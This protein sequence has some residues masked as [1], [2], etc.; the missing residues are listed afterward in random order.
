M[1]NETPIIKTKN[2]INTFFFIGRLTLNNISI[3]TPLPTKR[4][5][6]QEPK[7]IA[8]ERYISVIITLEAQFGIRPTTPAKIGAK[9]L[10]LS[11]SFAR[12]SS[13]KNSIAKL[14]NKD[15][16]KIKKITLSV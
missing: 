10:F 3:P 5:D 12:I 11:N 13:P 9:I 1:P 14:R 16:K 2:A 6:K 4:P 8:L 7:L 15:T